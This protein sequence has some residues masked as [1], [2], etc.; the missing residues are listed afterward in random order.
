MYVGERWGNWRVLIDAT[1]CT[2]D[3]A[4]KGFSNNIWTGIDWKVERQVWVHT[5]WWKGEGIV[6]TM[7]FEMIKKELLAGAQSSRNRSTH[8]ELKI[9]Y[10]QWTSRWNHEGGLINLVVGREGLCCCLV[11]RRKGIYHQ[12][13]GFCRRGLGEVRQRR[14]RQF[15]GRRHLEICR[16]TCQRVGLWTS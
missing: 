9:C 3:L 6:H 2:W 4:C 15:R 10:M 7:Y 5:L 13:V 1:T 12:V 8:I 14:G 16:K 11:K